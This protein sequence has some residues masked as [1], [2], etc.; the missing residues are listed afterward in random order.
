MY[1]EVCCFTK[2][3]VYYILKFGLNPFKCTIGL[4]LRHVIFDVRI[5]TSFVIQAFQQTSDT[6]CHSDDGSFHNNKL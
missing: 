6:R 2:Q 3:P 4:P 1:V 5:L